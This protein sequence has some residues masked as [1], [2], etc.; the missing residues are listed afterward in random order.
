VYVCEA[1]SQTIDLRDTLH[2][3]KKSFQSGLIDVKDVSVVSTSIP[4]RDSQ[5]SRGAKGREGGIERG[6]LT[7]GV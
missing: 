4:N 7:F 3:F 5:T 2:V 1:L 6:K